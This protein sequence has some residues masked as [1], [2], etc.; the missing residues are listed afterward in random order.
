MLYT[1]NTGRVF[2]GKYG[3]VITPVKCDN[4]ANIEQFLLLKLC[5]VRKYQIYLDI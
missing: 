3:L 2:A 1:S 5:C 4:P